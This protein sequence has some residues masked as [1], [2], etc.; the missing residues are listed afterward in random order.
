M[1][2]RT[3][4]ALAAMLLASAAAAESKTQ[5]DL[6]KGIKGSGAYGAA[7]CGLGSMA[8]GSQAGAVQILA[9]TTNTLFGTQTFGITTGTSNCGP[10]LFAMGTKN[11]VEANREAVAKDISRGE[12]EAIGALT[13]INGCRDS[14]AVGAALQRS[15][16]AIFP[17]EQASSDEV[18]RAIL[19]TLQ[20][21]P[22]LGCAKG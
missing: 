17:S 2:V 15:F 6:E 4:A 9:A 8:F 10:S 20:S 21:E 7:G 1:S 12:G 11:F 18:T 14:R 16:A 5:S 22:A 19:E 3:L 13:V